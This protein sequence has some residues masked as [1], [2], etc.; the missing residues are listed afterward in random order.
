MTNFVTCHLSFVT[1]HLLLADLLQKH[2]NQPRFQRNGEDQPE[3]SA[4]KMGIMADVVAAIFSHII[5]IANIKDSKN[6][7]RYRHRDQKKK[8]FP[9]R[10][11]DDA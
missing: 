5:F 9:G 11:E 7:S 1:C 2:P 6:W 8:Y 3:Q 4:P 10:I